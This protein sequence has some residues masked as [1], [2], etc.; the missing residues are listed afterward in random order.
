MT[1][2][3]KNYKVQLHPTK[4]MMYLFAFLLFSFNSMLL[5]NVA[6]A[7]ELNTSITKKIHYYCP[8]ELRE[9]TILL[10]INNPGI[11]K[12][13]MWM[14]VDDIVTA[15]DASARNWDKQIEKAKLHMR[16]KLKF[17]TGNSYASIDIEFPD[18]QQTRHKSATGY[19]LVSFSFS[20][21]VR[22][23]WEISVPSDMASLSL[24]M[25]LGR[26]STTSTAMAG[27][28]MTLII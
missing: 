16:N 25:F 6:M 11:I 4:A 5:A 13:S 1:I 23:V 21:R 3:V 24:E 12:G 10:D 20:K 28:S 8:N 18:L 26:K 15:K 19:E 2:L 14:N 9:V 22:G 27:E 17:L 7:H